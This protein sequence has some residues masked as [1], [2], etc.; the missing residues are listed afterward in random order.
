MATQSRADL[1]DAAL[2]R[3]ASRL[4]LAP[5]PLF[6]VQ[7]ILNG[8]A[9]H[10]AKARPDLFARLGP[11]LNKRFLIDPVELPFVLVLIPN[12][13]SPHLQAFRR[14]ERPLHDARITG[15]FFDLFEMIEGTSDG[16]ALFFARDLLI[17]GDVEAVVALR[18]A[19]DDFD[20]NIV[21]TILEALGPFSRPAGL[22]IS[23][24][25]A[26]RTGG[27]RAA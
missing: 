16:D 5:I 15:T 2:L 21:E 8:V 11:H 1:N 13:A 22:F 19:L 18:N 14:Y 3:S 12:P 26:M 4:V 9:T 25:R 6:L 23:A 27:R 7:P 20:G 17:E 24:L 10:A